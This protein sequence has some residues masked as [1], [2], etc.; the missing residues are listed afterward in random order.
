MADTKYTKPELPK[1]LTRKDWDKN[2]GVIA[3]MHGKTGIGD[4]LDDLKKAYDAVDWDALNMF[5][6]RMD[7]RTVTKKA[8]DKAFDDAKSEM[9]GNLTSLSKE[10][11]KVRDKCQDA[12]AKFKKSKTIPKSSTKHVTEMATTADHLGVATNK[13][14]M[15]P[16]LRNM[17]DEYLEHIDKYFLKVFVDGLGKVLNK[18]KGTV[19]QVKND[20]TAENFANLGCQKMC[21]DFTTGLGNIS[22]AADK[23]F[24]VKG[25]SAAGKLFKVIGPYANLQVK[26]KAKDEQ[27]IKSEVLVECAKLD[28]FYEAVDKFHSTV[29]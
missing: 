12:A 29:V 13:N 14:S 9:T 1:I 28:K 6:K 11:Y 7:W 19:A 18:H 3:K 22:K 15:S 25:A 24:A 21:R 20:P 5:E 10:L 27:G 4:A 26:I 23:G 16:I 8:W 2:K 17:Y